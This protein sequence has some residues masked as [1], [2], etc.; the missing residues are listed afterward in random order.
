MADTM[1]EKMGKRKRVNICSL[2]K[3]ELA[4]QLYI[5]GAG[6]ISKGHI[7]EVRGVMCVSRKER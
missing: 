7:V 6:W 2:F 1:R 3:Q 5:H 4:Q